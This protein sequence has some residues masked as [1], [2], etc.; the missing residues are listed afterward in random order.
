MKKVYAEKK[1]TYMTTGYCNHYFLGLF[2]DWE[3]FEITI[4]MLRGLSCLFYLSV[5]CL[6]TVGCSM[7]RTAAICSLWKALTSKKFSIPKN[8]TRKRK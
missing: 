2:R 4:K 7:G 3:S 1:N 5:S 6:F 8:I